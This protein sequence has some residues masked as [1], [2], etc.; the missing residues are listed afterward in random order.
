MPVVLITGC[1]S[2]FGLLAAVGFAKRGDRVFA[3]M[4]NVEKAAP[5]RDAASAAGVEVEILQLDVADKTSVERAVSDVIAKAGR[6]DVLVNNAGIGAVA[7]LEDFDDDEVQRVF[8]TNVF[9]VIRVTRAVLP[10]MRAQRSGRIVHVGSLAAIVPNQFRGIYAATKSAVSA[11]SDSLYYEGH[12]WGI[13]SCVVEPGFF[14]TSISD[15][16]MPTRRQG[17]S[18]YAPLLQKYEGATKTPGGSDR[19]NPQPVADIIVQAAT[20]AE[21]KRHY[22]VGQDAESIVALKAK[23]T[24]DEFAKV[25]LRSMPTLDGSA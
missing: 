1:S 16:R 3:T 24:D 7:A 14:E 23:L 10:H 19:A 9:G 21:P 20:E 25:I 11:L 6:I 5:L 18:D 2:G 17:S 8:D 4:R 22:P 12:P 15:N 13:H